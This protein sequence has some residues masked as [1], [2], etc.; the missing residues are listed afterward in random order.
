MT[1]FESDIQLHESQRM[2]DT[3]D[4]G[5][6]MTGKVIADGQHNSIY[7][8]ISDLDRGFGVCNLRKLFLA[9]SNPDTDVYFGANIGVLQP[10]ADPN[11]AITLMSTKDHYDQRKD[12]KE[13]IE[14][15]LARGVRW[16]GYLYDTQLKGQRAIRLI[17]RSSTRLPSVGEV[18]VLVANEN[19]QTEYEQYVRVQK[20]SVESRNF[21]VNN[22]ASEFNREVVTCEITEPL[23]YDFAGE[24]PSPYDV[25]TTQTSLRETIVA[26]AAKYYGIRPLK[27]AAAFGSFNVQTDGI[28]SQLVPSSRI[29]TPAVDLAATGQSTT[30]MQ[31][32]NGLARFNTVVSIAPDRSLY[33]GNSA[34]PGLVKITI[35]NAVISDKAG[36]LMLNGAVVGR[37]DYS[38]GL[39]VFNSACPNYASET[40]AIEFMPAAAPSVTTES[41][42]LQVN[43]E[44]RGYAWTATLGPIPQPGTCRVAYMVQG[45]WYELLDSGDGALRGADASHGTGQLTQGSG[46]LMLTL[47]A[48][49]DVDS[50]ILISWGTQVDQHEKTTADILCGFEVP[51]DL[52]QNALLSTLNITW[53]DKTATCGSNG[54]ITGDATGK[55]DVRNDKVIFLPNIMPPMGTQFNLSWNESG[56]RRN[57][58]GELISNGASASFSFTSGNIEPNSVYLRFKMD[59]DAYV[60]GDDMPEY[61]ESSVF[62]WAH[63]DGNGNLVK[64]YR[65]DSGSKEVIGSI[66][67]VSGVG[68]LDRQFNVGVTQQVWE[69][70]WV[71]GDF[72]K[73]T[74]FVARRQTAYVGCSLVLA[75]GCSLN[76]ADASAPTA[77]AATANPSEIK[78]TV[79]LAKKEMLVTDSLRAL[80]AG[81]CYVDRFGKVYRDIDASTGIGQECGQVDASNGVITITQWS[82]D[83]TALSLQSLMSTFDFQHLTQYLAF[84]TPGAPVAPGSLYL[85]CIDENGANHEL[86][87]PASGIIN[88]GIFKGKFNHQTGI[89][90]LA[91]AN[92]VNA[93]SLLFNCV[94]YDYLPLDPEQIGLDPV[95]LPSDGRVPIY[96]KGDMLL[97]HQTNILHTP[98][99]AG[100]E[101]S[102]GKVRLA[103]VW[104]TDD[105]GAVID[106]T[107][108]TEDLDAG[109]VTPVAGF[110]PQNVN[111]HY[112][113]ED[114]LMCIDVD[115]SG[116]IR[117]A[118]GLSHDYEANKAYVSSLLIAGDLWARYTNLYEQQ[119]WTSEFADHL[120]GSPTTAQFN[121]ADYPIN[122]T[123]K[124]AIT[125]RWAIVFTSS[126]NFKLIGENVGQIA[127][128]DINSD[129]APN[130]PNT[131]TPYLTINK[132]A[133]G[134][135]WA[136]NNTVRFNTVG[137]IFP[138]WP[139]RT[140]LQ[141][142][143]AND[144]Y[145]F[146]LLQRGNINKDI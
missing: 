91:A 31:S 101:I 138:F 69:Q 75:D 84:R 86:S 121:D 18:L 36:D 106:Q 35:G 67:Y 6:Q 29:E 63:D 116:Q 33:L 135:G 128:G 85:R 103:D 59:I 92:R 125:E 72:G 46:S 136:T 129:F 114:Q 109:T 137:A 126:T 40:K 57:G 124:G 74:W 78:I 50:G 95:R 111:I 22:S 146:A 38:R 80:L 52:P 90:E 89:C 48:L 21:L 76:W 119:T 132:L 14:Q 108:Y 30:L 5:G 10:P 34:M 53:L 26:N 118:R 41:M 134:A 73:N 15:Y 56:L 7:P 66:D 115:I 17:Q 25:R 44:N 144:N 93:A 117:L 107:L 16:Q 43:A 83:T 98:A 70:K 23:R 20:V 139:I 64:G 60:P 140:V 4:G 143:A 45:K 133:W 62:M 100:V 28:F 11:V 58:V 19:S 3:Q 54:T 79:P 87:V 2:T 71:P 122:V 130:N 32:S 94:V 82:P 39:C 97:I 24:Q 127:V 47:G 99:Q 96:R 9:I 68:S 65:T 81:S 145:S 37:V 77:N 113:F 120:I 105:D 110:S 55:F 27:T 42:V 12:A 131:G 112:R 1:I 51:L 88:S 142:P 104:L 123:N 49:P 102:L 141:G 8:D 61:P 13:F